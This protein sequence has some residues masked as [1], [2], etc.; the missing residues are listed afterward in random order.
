MINDSFSR[1]TTIASLEVGIRGLMQRHEII[2]GNISNAGTPNY[3]AKEVAFEDEL[4]KIQRKI[5]YGNDIE[6]SNTYDEHFSLAASSVIEAKI[7]ISEPE[8]DF[9]TNGN[10]VD[11]D[12]EMLILGKTGMKYKAVANMGKRF[13]EH[14]QAIIR[15]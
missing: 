14:M 1:N 15:G 13:F 2:A 9:I 11:L 10:N 6:L 12:R 7:E 3:I 5:R 4:A 8:R